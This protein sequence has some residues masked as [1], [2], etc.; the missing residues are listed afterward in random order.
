MANSIKKNKKRKTVLVIGGPSGVGESTITKKI[1]ERFPIF[2]RL[3]TATTRK[4]RLGEK[5]RVDY[6]FF[7]KNKFSYPAQS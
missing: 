3:V 4:P 1:I 7:S 2:K 5:N 6:Y